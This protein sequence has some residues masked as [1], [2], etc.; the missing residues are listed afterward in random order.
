MDA[1]NTK[2]GMRISRVIS[3]RDARALFKINQYRDFI[4]DAGADPDIP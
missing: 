1:V 3:G 4:F 2:S